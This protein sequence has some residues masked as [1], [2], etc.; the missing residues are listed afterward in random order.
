MIKISAIIPTFKRSDY[1]RHALRSLCEQSL[2]FEQYEIIVVDNAVEAETEEAVKEFDDGRVNLRYVT[3]K[4]VGLN[5]A[6]NAGLNAAAGRYVAYID[7]DA[8]AE[9]N[10][11]EALVGAFERTSP[12]PAAVG[13]RVW[14]DW[15]GERPSWVPERQLVL[16]TYVDHGDDARSLE[17]H[18]YLVGANLAFDRE[19]LLS[20]GGFD[21]HLDRQGSLL[22]SGGDT[23]ALAHL[24]RIGKGVYY[25]PAALVWHS[26]L[27]A[28]KRPSWLLKRLFWDGATQPLL[29]R[30][31]QGFSREST[32]RRAYV[33]LRQCLRWGGTTIAATITG[34]RMRAWESLLG[35]SQRAGRLRTQIRLLAW[36]PD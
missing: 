29:D 4:A 22:L 11:L 19:D 5:R 28:R 16:F 18:E 21:P 2:P 27:E 35:L 23:A 32:L 20:I 14:L 34:K 9:P 31:V 30:P 24:Q 15:H 36:N 3:E 12:A 25:E 26:V 7:D 33:D 10:W 17:N 6:R 8:R 1:L 13:G